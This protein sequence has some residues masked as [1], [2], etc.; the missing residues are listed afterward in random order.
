M[1]IRSSSAYKRA[2]R[3]V[4]SRDNFCYLCGEY[5]DKTLPAFHPLS[6]EVDHIVPL[7]NGG[8]P[9]DTD[10]MRLTHRLCNNKKSDKDFVR[11]NKNS[12][13]QVV[14]YYK[15]DFKDNNIDWLS[16]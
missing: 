16:I 4:L 12:L 9:L 2:R 10:N 13:K 6:P 11:I 3:V 14:N 7:A 1:D 15:E 5:V 8:D